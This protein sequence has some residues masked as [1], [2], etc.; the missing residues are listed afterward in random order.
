MKNL[1]K[2]FGNELA[3]IVVVL[4]VLLFTVGQNVWRDKPRSGAELLSS[5]A[6]ALK[7]NLQKQPEP[8]A[9][10][11]DEGEETTEKA[12]DSTTSTVVRIVDGDTVQLG[13]GERLR[14]IGIDAPEGGDCYSREAIARNRALVLDKEV[15]IVKDT[16]E[17]DRY[18]RLLGYVY[19]DDSFVNEELV[20]G[21]YAVAAAYPPDTK[22]ER[23][24]AEAESEALAAKVGLW[25]ACGFSEKSR[26]LP[27]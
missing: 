15:R 17:R 21:G 4:V 19:V 16:S 22:Y 20:R 2:I 8:D 13:S 12:P 10:D 27:D 18:G 25:S 24:F 6:S 3:L 5:V 7:L 9:S 14:Y 26:P 11:K 23:T 1:A